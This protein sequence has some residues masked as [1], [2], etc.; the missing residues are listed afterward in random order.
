MPLLRM[1]GCC[2]LML[3]PGPLGDLD[4]VHWPVSGRASVYEIDAL[5]WEMFAADPERIPPEAWINDEPCLVL[6]CQRCG[7]QLGGGEHFAD[8]E[9]AWLAGERDGWLGDLCAAC[10]PAHQIP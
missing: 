6:A 9:H 10:Q 4:D 5:R 8:G 1:P 7:Q 2:W 3:V